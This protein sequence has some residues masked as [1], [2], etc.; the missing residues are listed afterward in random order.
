VFLVLIAIVV[1]WTPAA[2]IAWLVS[3]PLLLLWPLMVPPGALR[4]EVIPV[5]VAWGLIISFPD[6]SPLGPLSKAERACHK[7]ILGV[8][9]GARAAY[10][11][12]TLAERRADFIAELEA[13]DPPNELW[14]VVK[15]AQL[16]DMR[17]DPP[18]VGVGDAT[19]RLVSWPWRVALDHQIVLVRLRLDDA[20]R[21][22]RLRR[23]PRPGFDDMTSVLRYDYFFLRLV[24]A[25]FDDL[26]AREGGLLQWNE[27][28]AALLTLS[29]EVRPPNA[30]WTKLR[31]VTLEI[32]S[33]EVKAASTDLDDVERERLAIAI[34][35]ARRAWVELEQR[36]GRGLASAR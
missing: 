4:L 14:R 2:V 28:A 6:W 25:R 34:D 21:A 10:R 29:G 27:E 17:A 15:T 1:P 36:D 7:V 33:V 31:D 5:A 26:K 22:R 18:Q 3:V 9:A 30:N 32:Q 24:V 11:A 35:E 13:L 8:S 12:D 19:Q 23:H 16:L 20:F